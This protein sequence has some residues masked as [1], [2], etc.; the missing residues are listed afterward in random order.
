MHVVTPDGRVV[1]GYAADRAM[2]WAVPA[3]WALLPLLYAPGARPIGERIYRAVARRRQSSACA[4][5]PG[6]L[7]RQP[8]S[9]AQS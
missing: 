1:R 3:A 7:T 6:G 2:A 9:S 4:I 5:E 8:P